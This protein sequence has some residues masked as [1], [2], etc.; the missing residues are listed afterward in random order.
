MQKNGQFAALW[1]M[2]GVL[3][4]TGEP[5]YIT[6]RDTLDEIGVPYSRED[7]EATFGMNNFGVLEFVFG[8]KPDHDLAVSLS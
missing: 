2:D 7:F 3:V 6:W 8:E 4:D 1:D 5:H